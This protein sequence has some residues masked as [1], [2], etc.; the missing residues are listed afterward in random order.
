MKNFGINQV[1]LPKYQTGTFKN[2]IQLQYNGPQYYE[3][4]K[5]IKKRT[6][7]DF[8]NRK[9]IN[10]DERSD[11]RVDQKPV[12]EVFIKATPRQYSFVDLG[13]TPS[14]DTRTHAERNKDYWH[15]RKGAWQRNKT[16]FNNGKHLIQGLVKTAGTAAAVAGTP[17]AI[18]DLIFNPLANVAAL[19][20]GTVGYKVG[21][22]V[23]NKLGVNNVFSTAGSML[24]GIPA[25]VWGTGATKRGLELLMRANSGA[26]NISYEHLKDLLLSKK[27]AFNYILTGN[28]KSLYKVAQNL[29]D[30]DHLYQGLG[31]G[32]NRIHPSIPLEN[33]PISNFLYRTEPAWAKVVDTNDYGVHNQYVKKNYPNKKIKVY[34]VD[35]ID[36]EIMPNQSELSQQVAK[37]QGNTASFRIKDNSGNFAEF[38]AS[39]HIEEW[40]PND[41]GYRLQDIWKFNPGDYKKKHFLTEYNL[42]GRMKQLLSIYG[43]KTLD[44]HGTPFITRTPF[45]YNKSTLFKTHDFDKIEL[46]DNIKIPDQTYNTTYDTNIIKSIDTNIIKDII[47]KGITNKGITKRN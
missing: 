44:Y 23:D 22:K 47:D 8:Y 4:S 35:P 7:Q 3:L 18:K 45:M 6:N 14:D 31:L 24:F 37:T 42:K 5:Q 13:G 11:H 39:G 36:A 16:Q 40:L 9:D 34:E 41:L 19:G 20:T 17:Y 26:S 32:S 2:G 28:K 30:K 10:T 1:R 43:L 12:E 15:W 38:D 29:A 27:D 21:E 25:Q 46:S 33:D